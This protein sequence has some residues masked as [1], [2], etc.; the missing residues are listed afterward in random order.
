MIIHFIPW[1][2]ATRYAEK[3]ESCRTNAWEIQSQTGVFINSLQ[4]SNHLDS[5]TVSLH[6]P[7]GRQPAIWAVQGDY[8]WPLK[9]GG[10]SHQSCKPRM[11]CNRG[12]PQPI[13][14]QT[15]HK[16]AMPANIGGH[17]SYP[18]DSPMATSLRLCN[19]LATT[20]VMILP[21]CFFT[22]LTV[23]GQNLCPRV[24]CDTVLV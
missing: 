15:N 24:D 14:R 7:N 4:L 20:S 11:F 9:S 23:L 8:Q 10:N 12:I 13:F 19:S 16:R 2:P 21:P 3:C 5:L 17:I 22:S 1:I 6:S 18:S